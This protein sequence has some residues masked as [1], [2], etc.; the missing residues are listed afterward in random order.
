M[1]HFV[2]AVTVRWYNACAYYA[3]SLSQG[4]SALGHRVTV[5]GGYDTPAV[6]KAAELGL[7]VYDNPDTSSVVLFAYM[8]RVKAYRKFALENNLALVNAHNGTDHSIWAVA[9]RGTGIPIVRTSGNQIP[10]GRNAVSRFIVLKKTAGIIASCRTISDYYSEVFGIESEKI[11]VINGGIDNEYYVGDQKSCSL[12]NDLGIPEDAFVFG[13]LARFSLDKGHRHFFHAAEIV[14]KKYPEAWF[15]V[16][17]WNAQLTE[18]DMRVMSSEAGITEHTRFAGRYPD[19]RNL[20][21][22]LDAGVIAS[23]NS[24]TICRIAMEYMAMG[25]PVIATDTNVLPE[26]VSHRRSGLV[27][28]AGDPEKM[29]SAMEE[30]LESREKVQQFG[31]CGRKTIDSK[32]SLTSFAAQTLKAYRSITEND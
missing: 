19:T 22:A 23:V 16:A 28:P 7:D 27:V 20:I 15:L 3:V 10:P 4:L 9:L 30:M 25:V 18:R 24:E 2:Q 11:P 31:E 8:K 6:K 29:A 12:R 21:G 26:I 1:K 5:V 13:I 14:F 17:G 32:Y